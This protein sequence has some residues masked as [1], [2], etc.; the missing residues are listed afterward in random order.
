MIANRGKTVTGEVLQRNLIHSPWHWVQQSYFIWNLKS[1][2]DSA[3]AN[4]GTHGLSVVCFC[5]GC[6]TNQILIHSEYVF[7]KRWCRNMFTTALPLLTALCKHW[8]SWETRCCRLK[9][10]D[11]RIFFLTSDFNWSTARDPKFSFDWFYLISAHSASTWPWQIWNIPMP[12]G[13][14]G[15]EL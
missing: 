8:G 15:F 14:V 4:L 3:R 11:F 6:L 12:S 10:K 13:M 5:S 2:S 1:L 9:S 7:K